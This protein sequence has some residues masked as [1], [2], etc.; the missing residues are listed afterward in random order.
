MPRSSP[1]QSTIIK[2]LASRALALS[3]AEAQLQRERVRRHR[4]RNRALIE[5]IGELDVKYPGFLKSAITRAKSVKKAL[6][7]TGNYRT[8]LQPPATQ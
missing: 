8:I 5:R 1:R 3:R 4:A 6:E 2:S 7:R